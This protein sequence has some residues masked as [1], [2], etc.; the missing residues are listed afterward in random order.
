LVYFAYQYANENHM[1]SKHKNTYFFASKLIS[2]FCL[3]ILSIHGYGQQEQRYNRFQY[4]KYKWRAFHT[5]AFHIYF[6]AGYDSLCAFVTRELPFAMKKV[7]RNMTTTLLKEPSVIIY[8][9]QD[10]LYE[11]NIGL[12]EQENYPFPTF[13]STGN[14]MVLAY[15]GDYVDLKEQLYETIA[16]SIWDNQLKEDVKDQLKG[17]EANNKAVPFWLKEGA[18]KY[19]AHQWPVN[20]EDALKRS[21]QQ[22]DFQNWEASISYQPRLS[23][24]AFCYFLNQQY[25]PQA[26]TQLYQQLKKK[27]FQRS[28]RLIT[29]KPMDSVFSQCLQFYKVRFALAT[30]DTNNTDT[31]SEKVVFKIPYK[32]GILRYLQ[33]NEDKTMAAYI[34]SRNNTRTAYVCNL[35]SGSRNKIT[36]YKLPPWIND[37]SNDQYPLVKWSGNDLVIAIPE[38]GKMVLKNYTIAGSVYNKNILT[39]ADGINN[40]QVDDGTEYML[41]AFR[42]G[43][44]DIVGYSRATDRYTPYTSDVFDDGAFAISKSGP[45]IFQSNRPEKELK[46]RDT[47][48]LKPGLY[49][50]Q[51][52]ATT[53]VITDTIPYN[54]WDKPLSIN[55]N[56]ILATNKL[57]GTEKIA[58]LNPSDNGYTQLTA[59]AP[60]QYLSKTNEM[61]F[62]NAGKDSITI[63]ATN[64][65]E[66]ISNNKNN[67]AGSP[68]LNDYLKTAAEQARIDS[69][70]KAAK[71]D[72]PSFL[73]SILVPKNAK[74]KSKQREDSINRSLDYNPKRV[75]PYVLQLHS[76]YFTAKINNDYFI[77]RYQP[78]LNY[79]GQFKFPELGG[80]VQGGFTDLLENHHINIAFRLPA[81]SEG[82]DFFFK[83][84][85]TAKKWDWS[86]SYFRKVESLQPDNKKEWVNESGDRYPASAKVKTHY[87][88]LSLK[89]PITYYLSAGL[90]TAVRN[91]RTIFLATEDYSLT[92]EDIKSLWSINT[93]NLSLNKIKPTIPLLNK[94]YRGK[95]LLDVFKGLSQQEPALMGMQVQGTYHLPIY[96]YITLVAQGKAGYSAGDNYLLYNLG[97]TDNNVAPK[98]DTSVQFPQLAPYAFQTLITP[99]RGHLQNSLYGNQF[100]VV[101]ADVYFPLFQTLIPIETPLNFINLL[102]PGLFADAGTAKESWDKTAVSKGWLWSYGMSLRTTLANYPLRLDVAWPG[103]FGKKPVWYFSLNLK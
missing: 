34:L 46:R 4:H 1:F 16:R 30:K 18:I 79:Q 59:Y 20:S 22:K 98:R 29:K 62:Y 57:D 101:N 102:Q 72:N 71:D 88:E 41:N 13:L 78:Y 33:L 21:F 63:T 54:K 17:S 69:I 103:T 25:Y 92:F 93:L 37:Y 82:S 73:E 12:Y 85:N 52:K 38:K 24:Q 23:G 27:N 53:P 9:S 94:G 28:L 31:T 49:S 83:Y 26:V 97:G 68:W 100:A 10:Q 42:K 86:L 56:R 81:A 50:V 44:S 75:K 39:G 6:P 51:G 19:F 66:W 76:A 2:I 80:M 99:F 70:L 36:S 60:P 64:A 15:T 90:Q 45:I 95:V 87:Y 43:Q 91:D 96:K 84:E 5:K 55:S 58:L 89:Y 77:N 11:S 67:D 35:Q 32:K 14:R 47:V 61:V 48:R 40:M 74:E 3:L 7:K 8:P 65:D